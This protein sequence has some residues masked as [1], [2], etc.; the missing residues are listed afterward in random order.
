MQVQLTLTK[1]IKIVATRWRILRLKCTKFDLGGS[2]QR[3][4]DPL[5]GFGGPTSKER[6]RDGREGGGG[7]GKGHEPP[8]HYL[9][10]VYAY[11]RSC[12]EDVSLVWL[13]I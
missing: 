11:G 12:T 7:E 10:E 1:I 4:P 8:P 5:A 13:M 2:L 6:G 9:E 3:S